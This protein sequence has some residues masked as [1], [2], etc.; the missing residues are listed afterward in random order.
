M[1]VTETASLYDNLEQMSVG[2]ILTNINKEDAKVHVAVQKRNN[3][4]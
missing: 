2:E 4:V 1:K 3:F